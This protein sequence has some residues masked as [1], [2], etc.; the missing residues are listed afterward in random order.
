MTLSPAN[1]PVLLGKAVTVTA[2]VSNSTSGVTWSVDNIPGGNATVG[3]IAANAAGNGGANAQDTV[4][5]TFTAPQVLPASGTLGAPAT[6]NITATSVADPTKVAIA[7]IAITSDIGVSISPANLP[8][9]LGAPQTFQAS[10][11]S[12]GNPSTSILWKTAGPGCSGAACGTVNS[13][14]LFIAPQILPTAGAV[15][16]TATSVAD[17]SKSA[18]AT[19]TVTSHFTLTISASVSLASGISAGTSV[20]FSATVTPVSG[21]NPNSGVTWSV[22]GA[23]CSGNT[24]GTLASSGVRAGFGS[25][26]TYTAPSIAPAPSDVTITAVSVADPSKSAAISVT[27]NAAG[28]ITI[29]PTVATVALGS[30]MNFTGT[31]VGISNTSLTWDVNGITGGNSSVGTIIASSGAGSGN[32]GQ[33]TY[34]A[35][36]SLP[37]SNPVIIRVRS[38]V[39]PNDAATALVTVGSTPVSIQVSP[40]S[41]TLSVVHRETFQAQVL[42][43]SDTAALWEVNNISGGNSTV[44]Q[45]CIAASNPC[46][47]ATSAVTG[48]VDYLAPQAVPSPN[49]VKITA[50]SDADPTKTATSAVTILPHDIVSVSPPSAAVSPGAR[51]L[52]SASVAGTMNQQV[53]WNVAGVGCGGTGAPC[54]TIDAT[55]L[56]LASAA[57]PVPNTLSVVATSA[58]DT[59]RAASAAVT[60][61]NQ[62][63]II[64]LLPSSATAGAAGF[65]LLVSGANFAATSPG[66]GS[67]ILIGGSARSTLCASNADCSTSLSSADLAVPGNLSVAVQNPGGASSSAVV[68]IVV[69]ASQGAGNIVLTTSSPAATGKDIVVVDLSTSGSTSPPAE[70][71][72]SVSAM[73]TYQAS[74]GTCSLGGTPVAL[75]RP[76][77]G[78]ATANLC[79]FSL[80]GLDP[81]YTYTL[82]GPS[83]GDAAIVATSSL[84]FGIVQVTI[85]LPST[86]ATGPR[87][88]FIQNANFDLASASGAVVIE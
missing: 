81:L 28:S 22:A 38:T 16:V 73:G 55:G 63:T 27:I 45:I 26:A 86:A 72:L 17:P 24:C 47:P 79:V 2:T 1:A 36:V 82:S 10:I 39:N 67:V 65:S 43:S 61:S 11:T 4:V 12:A 33:A 21:S 32:A 46:E 76:A 5:A 56:Y 30:S 78:T 41:A 52:F 20:N 66:P 84:G 3:M 57:A 58:D 62:P 8:V 70:A 31:V 49:P 80:S 40:T 64:S 48:S 37:S 83:P 53:T 68:F 50:V 59:G 23:G 75:T 13:A 87:T 42:N 88:L 85:A 35:P 44:G 60:V 51:V 34:T 14:G 7:A 54:G 6:V 18:T 74:T 9:E 71:N 15:T 69:P 29:S 19:I 25:G 77:S